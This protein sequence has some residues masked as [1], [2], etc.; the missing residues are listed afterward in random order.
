L[1]RL[2]NPRQWPKYLFALACLA[3][4]AALFT[5]L[6]NRRT[7]Q[8]QSNP[9][10]SAYMSPERAA[11]EKLVPPPVPDDQN[12]AATPYFALHMDKATF[13]ES[14]SRWPDGFSRA[15][16]WPRRMPVLAESVEGRKT[17][18]FVWDMLAWKM[19]FEK[20]QNV[21]NPS[22]TRDEIAVSE[23]PNPTTNAQAALFV[24]E[25]LKPYQPVLDE[26]HAARQRPYARFNI[27]YNWDNPWGILLPHLAFIKQTC[28]LLRLKASAELAAGHA[29][30]GL[31]DVLLMLR[32]VNSIRD[33]PMVISQLVRVAGL[34]LAMQPIWEGLAAHR[35]SDSQLQSLQAALQK[36]DFLADLRH[37]LEAEKVWGNL[38]I[39]L[40]RDKQSPVSFSSLLSEDGK[41]D[42]WVKDAEKAFANVPRDW[43]DA[44]Q[45]NY[46]QVF[47]ERLLAGFDVGKR[48]VYPRA[49]EE[50]DH[51]IDKKLRRNK[52]T[53]VKEHLAFARGFLPGL[54][55]VHLKLAGAQGSLDQAVIACALER[56][57]LANGQYPRTLN[58][59]V[60]RYLKQVPHDLITGQPLRY[61]LTNDGQFLLYSIGW[62]EI[63]DGGELAFL[64]SG[65]GQEKKDGDWV[66]RYPAAFIKPSF[67]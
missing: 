21:L 10:A 8:A 24:L 19:A 42:A 13:Q 52:E 59:L 48:R 64:A 56:H 30:Q 12:F 50:N 39:A 31:Q 15:D 67:E 33:E 60:P 25:A 6:A 58:A 11:A 22:D 43:F 49:I 44:E 28:Q 53:V 62:N 35:W 47:D 41:A 1:Q 51:Q 27:R 16:Q 5:T 32:L 34:E 4:L 40:F 14:R 3:T 7:V 2:F 38:T 54:S 63:D 17:G 26:L 66:W 65:R 18:R 46:N 55:R 57:R 20:S 29:E 9:G 23:Q 36:Y 37:G 61:Q 45:R